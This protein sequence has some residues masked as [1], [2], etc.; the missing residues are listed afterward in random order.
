ME[1]GDSIS[2]ELIWDGLEG[3][4]RE[5]LVFVVG[6]WHGRPVSVGL[7]WGDQCSWEGGPCGEDVL[8]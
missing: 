3:S 2:M 1:L 6:D 4:T 8:P 5:V 7:C